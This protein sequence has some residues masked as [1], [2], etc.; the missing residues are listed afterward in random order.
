[1]TKK[2]SPLIDL[3][4]GKRELFMNNFGAVAQKKTSQVS[5]AGGTVQSRK[6]LQRIPFAKLVMIAELLN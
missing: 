1:M 6:I 3:K 4:Q 2:S 5:E